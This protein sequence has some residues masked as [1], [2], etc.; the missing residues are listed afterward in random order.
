MSDHA[1][2]NEDARGSLQETTALADRL[3]AESKQIMAECD[4]LSCS[5]P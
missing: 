4:A 1:D 5:T 3:I 2:F